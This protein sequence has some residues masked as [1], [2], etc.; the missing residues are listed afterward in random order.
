M[1][2]CFFQQ[3]ILGLFDSFIDPGLKFI[4]KKAVQAMDAVRCKILCMYT[5]THMHTHE[6]TY[7]Q[8]IRSQNVVHY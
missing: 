2:S 5:H 3:Y 8:T 6:H 1:F 7:P 4:K